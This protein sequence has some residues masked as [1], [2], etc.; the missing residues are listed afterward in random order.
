MLQH[1]QTLRD[2]KLYQFILIVIILASIFIYGFYA[3][4][5]EVKNQKVLLRQQLNE[6]GLA[7][8][9]SV[10]RYDFMPYSLSRNESI[11][12]LLRTKDITKKLEK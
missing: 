5:N 10:K 9:L 7:L 12:N 8:N 3:V 4:V 2:P 1:H 6:I 11:I